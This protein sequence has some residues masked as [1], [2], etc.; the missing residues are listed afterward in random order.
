MSTVKADRSVPY[1]SDCIYRKSTESYSSLCKNYTLARKHRKAGDDNRKYQL[2]SCMKDLPCGSY[3]QYLGKIWVICVKTFLHQQLSFPRHYDESGPLKEKQLGF[4]KT[5]FWIAR[6][7]FSYSLWTD[8]YSEFVS[9]SDTGHGPEKNSN[10]I[11]FP[12]ILIVLSYSLFLLHS[13]SSFL[14]FH[15]ICRVGRILVVS[16]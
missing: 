9:L 15:F 7:T 13:S 10:F 1:L 5:L 12:L 8:S 11:F 6:F 14:H 2:V 4:G 3:S 16:R